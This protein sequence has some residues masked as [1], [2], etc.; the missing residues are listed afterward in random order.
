VP[1]YD[2]RDDELITWLSEGVTEGPVRIVTGYVDIFGLCDLLEALPAEI[3]IRVVTGTVSDARTTDV[4][5]AGVIRS[6]DGV[7]G[8]SDLSEEQARILYNRLGEELVIRGLPSLHAKL[9]LAP[10]SG[11]V[12]SSNLTR[13]GLHGA[14]EYNTELSAKQHTKAVDWFDD[15]WEN[16]ETLTS[17]FVKAVEQSEHGV[18]VVDFPIMDRDRY[19]RV[20]RTHGDGAE[21]VVGRSLAGQIAR[22]DD[23]VEFFGRD[24]T[25]SNWSLGDFDARSREDET[26]YLARLLGRAATVRGAPTGFPETL[27]RLRERGAPA[28]NDAIWAGV[29]EDGALQGLP[30]RPTGLA[31][32][33]DWYL[34]DE[35]LSGLLNDESERKFPDEPRLLLDPW[36]HQRDAL[37]A[38]IDERHEG[39]VEMATGTG[40]TTVGLQA[41]EL[42]YRDT[43]RPS[44]V[45][46]LV[47]AH[48]TAL[49]DQW[50]DAIE[51]HLGVA[52]AGRVGRTASDL[53]LHVV[54]PHEIIERFEQYDSQTYDLVVVDEVHHYQNEDGWGLV[55]GLDTVRSLGLSA[56]LSGRRKQA[57]EK[58]LG[59]VVFQYSQ[60]KAVDDK[61]V[62]EFR[63]QLHTVA[64]TSDEQAD[65]D[66]RTRRI[67][68]TFEE[69]KSSQQTRELAR[70]HGI[71]LD[72]LGDYYRLRARVQSE[73]PPKW[74]QLDDIV[75]IRR[76]II[77]K[78]NQAI[79]SAIDLAKAYYD[80][81]M[82]ILIF[83]MVRKIADKI[84]NQVPSAE[85]IHTGSKRE[86]K[87]ALDDFRA[88]DDGILVG[89]KML[90]EGID[91]PNADVAIN[92]A[93]EK[94]QRQLVQRQGRILRR[95][96]SHVPVFHQ[97]VI[98]EEAAYYSELGTVDPEVVNE[99]QPVIEERLPTTVGTVDVWDVYRQLSP[100]RLAEL[101]D[102]GSL[103]EVEFTG[104]E[105]WLNIYRE[106]HPELFAERIQTDVADSD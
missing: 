20:T 65:Y 22:L 93:A 61:I 92:V 52:P 18:S 59:P 43:E 98:E 13:R 58:A 80:V 25:S 53:D 9:Y 1:Y 88:S 67:K 90:D 63:W 8:I 39:V 30:V 81:G 96:G 16:A 32:Y 40:K 10:D 105:W 73:I 83:T 4:E 49:V 76:N 45:R 75:R 74:G 29:R 26:R 12:G 33:L 72:D 47:V 85:A 15:R 77:Y 104:D 84:G 2:N 46:V 54:T 91:V 68:A 23:R 89:V 99:P 21:A 31:W 78:S 35:T 79:E 55:T 82:K 60:Q 3:S 41:I 57:I 69:V 24:S 102:F 62:P 42:T 101:D 27:R 34:R 64:L 86:G 51:K 17:E 48:T 106:E 14:I 6:G 66:E 44:T 36:E 94:T 71:Q 50:R 5:L 100:T 56:E 87:R 11:L 38:W 103:A 28:R 37:D 19:R 97:F 7:S 70:E 95:E